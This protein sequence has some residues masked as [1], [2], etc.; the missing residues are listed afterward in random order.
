VACSALTAMVLVLNARIY[1][2]C[3]THWMPSQR[4]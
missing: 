4:C 1:T 3:Q 2:S